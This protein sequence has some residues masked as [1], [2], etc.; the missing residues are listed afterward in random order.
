MVCAPTSINPLLGDYKLGN[1]RL[2]HLADGN[3]EFSGES[4]DATPL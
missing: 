1:F 3:R 4:L 2:D